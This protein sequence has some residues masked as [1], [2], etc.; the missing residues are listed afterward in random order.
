ME[1]LKK[2]RVAFGKCFHRFFPYLTDLVE[3]NV[4]NRCVFPL[5]ILAAYIVLVFII[6]A[7]ITK[8]KLFFSLLHLN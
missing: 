2:G 5:V 1:K 4:K 6:L 3:E 8:V 7:A